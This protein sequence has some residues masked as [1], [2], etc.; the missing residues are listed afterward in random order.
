MQ[1]R[2]VLSP[3]RALAFWGEPEQEAG[4]SFAAPGAPLA[5]PWTLQIEI[6]GTGV[7]IEF[8]GMVGAGLYQFNVVIPNLPSGD[9]PVAAVIAGVGSHN[10]AHITVGER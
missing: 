5:G 7:D 2:F 1:E 10:V 9:H 3:G 6:G 4:L 8:A